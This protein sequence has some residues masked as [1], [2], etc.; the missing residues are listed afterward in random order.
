MAQGEL[1][2]T[3]RAPATIVAVA[4]TPQGRQRG[5][6]RAAR[7]GFPQVTGEVAGAAAVRE[8]LVR[9]FPELATVLLGLDEASFPTLL[10]LD[11]PQ[12]AAVGD[13]ASG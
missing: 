1:L 4:R 2:A 5:A 8:E 7:E 11:V 9:W 13:R 12:P 3:A 10:Q 6:G